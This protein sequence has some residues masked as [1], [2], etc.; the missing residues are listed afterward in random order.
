VNCSRV[1]ADRIQP[2]ENPILQ[3]LNAMDGNKTLDRPCFRPSLSFSGFCNIGYTVSGHFA[4]KQIQFQAFQNAMI[5]DD[6]GG[7]SK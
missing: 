6:S 1:L 2:A 4:D 3:N 7:S 5:T